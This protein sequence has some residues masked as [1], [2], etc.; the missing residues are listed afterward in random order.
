MFTAKTLKSIEYDKI[1]SLVS[2]YAVLEKTK[3]DVLSFQPVP[4]L[5]G[6]EFLL[7]KTSE[8]YKLLYTYSIGGVYYFDDCLDELKRVDMGGTLINSEILKVTANLKSARLLKTSIASINDDSIVF[9]R[10]ISNRLFTNQEFEKEVAS[11]IIS[12]DEI[13]DNASPK[14]YQIRK[15]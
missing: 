4:N 9:L 15:S 6:A 1:M 11:I 2:S 13:S 10:E 12:D 7:K 5:S 8:A 14:L 3:E